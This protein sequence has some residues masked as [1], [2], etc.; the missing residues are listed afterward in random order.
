MCQVDQR[1]RVERGERSGDV[2]RAPAAGPS[3][4]QQAKRPAGQH[5]AR[6]RRD[7]VR[8]HGVAGHRHDRRRDHPLHQHRLRKGE[9]VFFRIEDAGVEQ[10]RR[11]MHER[12]SDP[13]V[14]QI[15]SAPSPSTRD[16]CRG[17]EASATCAPRPARRTP[18][19]RR[20]RGVY[21]RFYTYHPSRWP[22]QSTTTFSKPS[23]TRPSS[24]STASPR[25]S[26]P[27]RSTPRSRPPTPATRSRTA[28]R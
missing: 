13:A 22:D 27:R 17:A 20:V 12:V 4:D 19:T 23:A 14:A 10:A 2:T 1:E 16:Q 25:A 24:A 11:R 18:T 3:P 26:S 15:L 28:W 5:E 6:K 21:D 8:E 9:R 7:V